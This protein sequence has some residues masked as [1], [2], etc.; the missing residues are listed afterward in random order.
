V[1]EI[2]LERTIPAPPERI[3]ALVADH[4]GMKRWAPVR[5]VVLRRP[6]SPDPNGVG[7]VRTVRASGL[8]LD[9]RITGFK[10]GERLGYTVLEGAPL[11]D[12]AGEIRLEPGD[13][14]TR[15]RWSVRFRPLVPGTG[16]LLERVLARGL[17]RALAGL[18]RAVAEPAR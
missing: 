3:W 11:R 18:A 14:G 4:E 15:V 5:E 1:N 2:V 7:A 16:W 13:G 17:E 6:G 12:H 8:V 9:E 10:P